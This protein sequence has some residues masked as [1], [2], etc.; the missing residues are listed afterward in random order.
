TRSPGPVRRSPS[1][2]SVK[3]VAP[4]TKARTSLPT[5]HARPSGCRWSRPV[6]GLP[7]SGVDRYQSIMDGTVPRMASDLAVAGLDE[8]EHPERGE[9]ERD[10]HQQEGAERLCGEGTQREVEAA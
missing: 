5:V 6:A 4:C 9:A 7:R 3:Y 10:E 2:S 1:H 8:A